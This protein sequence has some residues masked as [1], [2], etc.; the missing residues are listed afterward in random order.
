MPEAEGVRAMFANIAG[1]YDLANRV[2]SGGMDIGWRKAL[3]REVAKTQPQVVVDLATGSG[4][5]AFALQ[6][7]LGEGVEVRGLD[8]CEPML[9]EARRKQ[10]KRVDGKSIPFEFGDCLNLPLEDNSVDVITISFG[11]RN[12]E[13]RATGLAEFHRVLRPG[14]HLFILEFSQPDKILRPLYYFYLKYI[15]PNLASSLTQDKSAYYYLAGS[16]E[17]FPTVEGIQKELESARFQN[18]RARRLTGCVVALHHGT[19]Y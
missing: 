11:Y 4:D 19:T 10:I 6:D 13:K 5:V 15:L 17:Q 7:G 18:V 9:E 1:R 8:F 3:V 2:L 14:G 16:I 12:L